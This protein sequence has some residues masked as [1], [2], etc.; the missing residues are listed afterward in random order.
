MKIKA[1]PVYQNGYIFYI[2][3]IPSSV[4]SK[5]CSTT[6]DSMKKDTDVYQRRLNA[7]RVSRISDFA[8]RQRAI[9]PTCIVLNS[10]EHLAYDKEKM[11][12]ELPEEKDSFFIVDGQ[13]RIE[14]IKQSDREYNLCV[15]ILNNESLDLQSELFITINGEQKAV[16]P[17]I[18]FNIKANDSVDTPEK[19]TRNI[20]D[21]LNSDLLSPLYNKIWM[22][23]SPRKRGDQPLSL[24]AFCEPICGYIYNQK[25]YYSIK[26]AL[27][28][29]GNNTMKLNDAFSD[30]K[31][32]ILWTFYADVGDRVLYKILFN[33]FSAIKDVYKNVWNDSKSSIIK[34]TG[35]NAFMLLFKGIFL[36]CKK[37]NNNY[38]YQFIKSILESNVISADNFYQP[39]VG[40]GRSAAYELYKKL[41]ISFIDF[42]SINEEYLELLQDDSWDYIV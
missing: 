40:L 30:Y 27:Y 41:Q 10:K 12:L 3:S 28:N 26:D 1:I 22:D 14:G 19:M 32:Y 13:H 33:Y 29:N 21:M 34:T 25:S 17:N 8:K 9:F 24:S 18:R 4:L 37:N 20:A 31:N 16:N 5:T 11:E 38:S 23:D 39:V 7:S 42:E 6:I 36:Y 35:Y 2:T 15:V